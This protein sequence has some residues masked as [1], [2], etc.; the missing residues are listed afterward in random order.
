MLGHVVGAI[1]GLPTGEENWSC[2]SEP[3]A[4]TTPDVSLLATAAV[5]PPYTAFPQTTRE[6]SLLIAA[7]AS[8]VGVIE[9]KFAVVREEQSPPCPGSPQQASVL[10]DFSAAKAY[11]FDLIVTT[12][13]V[14]LSAWAVVGVP[15]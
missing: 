6:P 9:T 15:P 2:K 5:L 4:W 14:S 7:M 1:V 12:P 13:L 3:N 11:L 8:V 10:S